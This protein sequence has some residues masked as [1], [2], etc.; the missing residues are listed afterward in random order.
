MDGGVKPSR[1]RNRVR[2]RERGPTE[3][4]GKEGGNWGR[5]MDGSGGASRLLRKPFRAPSAI[6][7]VAQTLP[8]SFKHTPRFFQ[9]KTCTLAHTHTHTHTHTHSPPPPELDVH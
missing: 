9:T 2:E 3:R 8:H 7:H 5:K 1:E 4:G 6:Q